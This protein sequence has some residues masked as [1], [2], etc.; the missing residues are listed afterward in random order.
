MRAG[1]EWRF[2]SRETDL[3]QSL[4]GAAPVVQTVRETASGRIIQRV[5]P[6]ETVPE[7][8]AVEVENAS[9]EPVEVAFALRPYNPEG[10]AVVE[11]IEVDG[12]VVR[13]DGRALLFLPGPASRFVLSHFKRGDVAG[14]LDAPADGATSVRDPAGLAQ[15]AFVFTALPSQRLRAAMPLGGRTAHGRWPMPWRRRMRR[16]VPDPTRLSIASQV[17][18]DWGRRLDRG[19]RVALPDSRLQQAVDANRA[20]LLVL[21]DPGAV[22]PGP[23]TYHRFWFR[24]AAYQV[25]A[26][27]R[28]GF[29]EEA[30]DVLRSYPGRQRADGFFYSQ[31]REWDANGC[32]IWTVAEHHRLT[33]DLALLRELAGPVARGADWI[34]RTCADREG[35]V[36][37]AR[38][39]L[40][41]GVSAEHLGPYDYYYWDNLWAW[42]GLLDAAAVAE[43]A[44]DL[45]A[46]ARARGAAASLRE[47]LLD[48]LE[49]AAKRLGRRVIPAGPTRGLDA[50]MIG[51]LAPAARSRCLTRTASGSSARLT[52]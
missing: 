23:Y 2:P 38:G 32:A 43:W 4:M 13:I 28:W 12:P 40:P 17:A 5:Y 36:P 35:K 10:L 24:D 15:A 11:H 25:A 1:G 6:V 51:S 44:G 3:R 31:W 29:H 21:H 30:D 16:T 49:L 18:A 19:L 34:A 9:P 45:E 33:G 14:L 37:E 50:G 20:F 42:R 52:S 48:S 22:T 26:L 27:D 8:V 39:L 41:A 46:A 7:L 47:A